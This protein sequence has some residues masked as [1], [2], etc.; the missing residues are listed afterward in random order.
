MGGRSGFI[1][2]NELIVLQTAHGQFIDLDIVGDKHL[3]AQEIEE[4][5]NADKFESEEEADTFLELLNTG[6]STNPHIRKDWKV[7]IEADLL[8]VKKRKMVVELVDE[9]VELE[10]QN[11]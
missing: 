2:K 9:H 8:P 5:Y 11:V 7:T 1:V 4:Y 6:K 3:E 10:A